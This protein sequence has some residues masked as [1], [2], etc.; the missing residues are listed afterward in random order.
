ML[1]K[2]CLPLIRKSSHGSIVF[3]ADAKTS[4]Y[5]GAYGVA[6]SGMEAMMTILA[7]ELES[8]GI[9]VNALDPG[10]VRTSFRTRAFPAENP[11]GLNKPEFVSGGFVYLISGE[12][13]SVTGKT[14]TLDDFK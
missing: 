8:K 4:A 12:T 2:A 13:D 9:M 6:K 3:T 1:T 14:F 7:D 11:Q 5:W 10:P